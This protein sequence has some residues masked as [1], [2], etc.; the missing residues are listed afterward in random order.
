MKL[1]EFKKLKLQLLDYNREKLNNCNRIIKVLA[2]IEE[3]DF[4]SSNQLNVRVR[5]LLTLIEEKENLIKLI[6][7]LNNIK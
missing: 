6:V 2:N 4:H 7:E 3:H 1:E 5:E